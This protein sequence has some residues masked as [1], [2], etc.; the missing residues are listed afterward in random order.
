MSQGTMKAW[1]GGSSAVKNLQTFEE[2]NEVIRERFL[3]RKRSGK[4][5]GE[6]RLNLSWSNW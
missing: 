2:K 3:A 5:L 1:L 6:G 4:G